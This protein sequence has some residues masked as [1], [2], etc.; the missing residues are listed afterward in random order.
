[1]ALSR[2]WSAFIIIAIFV[3][4]Y[5]FF[6]N[7]NSKIFSQLVIGKQGD[8]LYSISKKFNITIDELKKK[9]NILD[10][11]LSLGQIIIIK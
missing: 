6:F 8:T 10:N 2:I 7:H 11:A 4:G 1:M 5:Q 3:A 9:N